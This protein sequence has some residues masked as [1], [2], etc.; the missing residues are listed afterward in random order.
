M[1][2]FDRIAA[3]QRLRRAARESLATPAFRTPIDCTPWVTGGLWP[4]ELSTIT[5]ETASLAE[6][7]KA[8]L[9]RISDNANDELKIILQAE[10]AGSARQ[11]EEARVID[12]ARARAA[13]RV[14]SAV[15]HMHEV[16]A[17]APTGYARAQVGVR[18]VPQVG[19]R[20]VGPDLG[21]TEVLP[22][23]G[24][25][26][27]V[28][29]APT[30]YARPQVGERVVGPDLEDTQVLPAVGDAEPVADASPE[31]EPEPEESVDSGSNDVGREASPAADE[32]NEE[33][34]ATGG[35]HRAADK[36]AEVA[37]STLTP[38]AIVARVDTESDAQRLPRVLAFV[39][40][41]EPR[42]NWA[43]GERS[44]G[45]TV[46]V[47]DLAHGW[48]PP[49]ITLPAG[50]RLLEPERRS[51]AAAALVGDATQTATYAPGDRLGWSAD[52]APTN[53]S[54][55]PREL[56]PIDD[57]TSELEKATRGREGLPRLVYVLARGAA[58]GTRIVEDEV[59]LLRVHL[60]TTL[61]RLL[62]QHP[63]INPAVLLNCLLLAA[64]QGAVTGDLVSANYHL[65]WFQKLSAAPADR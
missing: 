13:R 8:D 3:R 65:A 42:L 53:T 58:E 17:G 52:F 41:Q 16:K 39:A 38:E 27:P 9:Q 23:V 59:D 56:P 5:A 20:V 22:A 62:L 34:E 31:A 43:V 51:G 19:E 40:R 50:V 37:A 48:I 28:V 49:G 45:T 21:E 35:R 30:G 6:Y 46:L 44:D 14:E 54:A 47:T 24:E 64:T 60:D 15:R 12:V 29:D 7:L 2:I 10:M 1:A 26:E 36:G 32:G 57:L 18:V 33:P 55:Q 63:D 25:V 11:A 61:R 4:A